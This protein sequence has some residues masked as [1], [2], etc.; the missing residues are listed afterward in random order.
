VLPT[1]A[2]VLRTCF[3][4]F[5]TLR[6]EKTRILAVVKIFSWGVVILRLDILPKKDFAV[7]SGLDLENV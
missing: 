4:G 6:A 3:D 2:R 5:F 7:E 1:F